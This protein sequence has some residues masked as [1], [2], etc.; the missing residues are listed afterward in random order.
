MNSLVNSMKHQTFKEIIPI[1]YNLF[2][3]TEERIK[4]STRS[5]EN[6]LCFY[7]AS[8]ILNPKPDKDTSR[9]NCRPISHE[10]RYKDPQ[11]NINKL[12][13]TMNKKNYSPQAK[14]IYFKY[15]RLV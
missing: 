2:Q 12:N 15:A 11:Q 9:S 10:H 3:K 14:E 4:F 13:T 7:E 8:I 6:T 5:R 1:L